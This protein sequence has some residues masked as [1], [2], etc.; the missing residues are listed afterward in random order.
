MYIENMDIELTHYSTTEFHFSN[1]HKKYN[2]ILRNI[3]LT[4]RNATL[5]QN[6]KIRFFKKCTIR[7]KR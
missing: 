6:F 2:L 4:A 1:E 5:R 3:I 7:V